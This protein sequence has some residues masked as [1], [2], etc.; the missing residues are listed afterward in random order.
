MARITLAATVIVVL[1]LGPSTTAKADHHIETILE[2]KVHTMIREFGN[3][4]FKNAFGNFQQGAS[5]CLSR[6]VEGLAQ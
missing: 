1:V 6:F 2:S 3:G 4:R 5:V